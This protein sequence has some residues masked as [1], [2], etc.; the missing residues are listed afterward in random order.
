MK[1]QVSS[2]SELMCIS[3]ISDDLAINNVETFGPG[4]A[5][6]L[7]ACLYTVWSR[8]HKTIILIMTHLVSATSVNNGA[9][10]HSNESNKS[11]L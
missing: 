9:N 6:L 5:A 2:V 8:M 1:L 4:H 11:L 7:A 10:S 3:Y